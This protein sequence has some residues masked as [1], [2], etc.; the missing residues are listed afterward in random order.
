[1]LLKRGYSVGAAGVDGQFGDGTARAV[2]L[3]QG[4]KGLDVDGAVGPRTWA[5]L[6]SRA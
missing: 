2:R 4:D 3:F 6:R 1:M 5:A